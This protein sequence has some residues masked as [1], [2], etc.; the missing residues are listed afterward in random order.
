MYQ[1]HLTTLFILILFAL[2]GCEEL[3]PTDPDDPINSSDPIELSCDIDSDMVLRNNPDAAVDYI[4]NC[5]VYIGAEVSIEAGTV[6][7][8]ASETGLIIEESSSAIL[9][10]KGTAAAPIILRGTSDDIGLWRGLRVLSTHPQNELSHTHIIGAGS[11]SFNGADV[12]SGIKVDGRVKIRNCLIEKSGGTGIYV[13]YYS[14]EN[15]I[16]GFA[17]NTIKDCK[18][19]PI[20]LAI[21]HVSSL[22]Q[23]SIFEGNT[24]NKIYILPGGSLIGDH[25]WTD[26][27]IPLLVDNGIYVGY[28]GDNASLNIKEGT[29]LQFRNDKS[30]RV[31]ADGYIHIQ[32]SASNPV[33]LVGETEA[34]GTWKGIY[35]L[36]N[37]V[38]NVIDNAII[39]HGASSPHDGSDIKALIRLGTVGSCCSNAQ[40]HISNSTLSYADCLYSIYQDETTLTETNLTKEFFTSEHCD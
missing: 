4:V 11:S 36:S 16:T 13:D 24:H 35:I 40:V 26:P 27:G 31:T 10:S 18:D 34:M 23:N 17:S 37:D 20:D 2:V 32:G 5:L 12:Q 6:I 1:K 15:A 14:E 28:A 9:L 39:S 30:L 22:D 3:S 38:R 8:F 33:R 25:V 7:E 21:F 29:E 19:Y